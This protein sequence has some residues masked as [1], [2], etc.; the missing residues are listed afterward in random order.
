M[1]YLGNLTTLGMF[2][3]NTPQF[4]QEQNQATLF[5]NIAH[6]NDKQKSNIFF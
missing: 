3:T 4:K 5:Y 1:D 6:K 2:S